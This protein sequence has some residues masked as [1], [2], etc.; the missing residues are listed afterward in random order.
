MYAGFVGAVLPSHLHDQFGT[1]DAV[2]RAFS[3][4]P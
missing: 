1:R 2:L 4:A 3:A